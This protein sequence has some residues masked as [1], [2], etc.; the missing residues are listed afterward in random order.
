MTDDGVRNATMRMTPWQDGHARG[1]TSKICC[2]SA[3]HRRA[4]SVGTSLGAGTITG[5]ASAATGS[6]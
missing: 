1:S 5:D 2:R 6:A 4:A 3:A